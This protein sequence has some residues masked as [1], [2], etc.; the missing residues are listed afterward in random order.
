MAGNSVALEGLSSK[1]LCE[2][3]I[4]WETL[5]ARFDEHQSK[6]DYV[7]HVTQDDRERNPAGL[8]KEIG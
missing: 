8:Q 7:T 1:W 3:L 6:G 2:A 4:T 5:T